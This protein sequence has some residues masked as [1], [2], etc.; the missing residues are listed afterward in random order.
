[1]ASIQNMKDIVIFVAIVVAVLGLFV[2]LPRMGSL[3]KSEPPRPTTCERLMARART[4]T[5][6][7]IVLS[8]SGCFWEFETKGKK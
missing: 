3:M 1:M 2:A 7:L 5:D 8:L 6:S 4:N